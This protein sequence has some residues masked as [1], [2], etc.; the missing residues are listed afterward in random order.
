MRSNI[1]PPLHLSQKVRQDLT[2]ERLRQ[3]QEQRAQQ[4]DNNDTNNNDDTSCSIHLRLVTSDIL[5]ARA[6]N[7][8]TSTLFERGSDEEA[9]ARQRGRICEVDACLLAIKEHDEL[10]ANTPAV[11]DPRAIALWDTA[12]RVEQDATRA[13]T[14]MIR[15]AA[16][17]SSGDDGDDEERSA[18]SASRVAGTKEEV[19]Q[20]QL[21]ALAE[22]TALYRAAT[23]ICP[24]VENPALAAK[25]LIP[26]R[27]GGSGEV[28]TIHLLPDPKANNNLASESAGS[29]TATPSSLRV[30]HIS[31]T[32]NEFYEIPPTDVLIHSGD[33]LDCGTPAEV[34]RF[35]YYLRSH[36]ASR[37]KVVIFVAGNH[38]M[39]AGVDTRVLFHG[40]R[41]YDPQNGT[42][43]TPV[44]LLNDLYF[45]VNFPTPRCVFCL[46]HDA[47]VTVG[48]V[49]IAGTPWMTMGPF[50]EPNMA[51]R[52][53]AIVRC[54][55]P[56][57][58]N[59]KQ[60]QHAAADVLVTHIPCFGVLDQAGL[61]AIGCRAIL[62]ALSAVP[63][64]RVVLHCFGHAHGG[65]GVV[66]AE[67]QEQMSA[68]TTADEDSVNK[69]ELPP[70]YTRWKE[71]FK[72]DFG[73]VFD[74]AQPAAA[75][76]K[77]VFSNAAIANSRDGVPR[78][79]N[80]IRML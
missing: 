15:S 24:E 7:L 4:S 43:L 55:N 69:T 38:E 56:E 42:S 53:D 54:I 51:A 30:V 72:T 71:H 65:F 17:A 8:L 13:A 66:E 5:W 79:F 40:L 28:K 61:M 27:D 60:E 70:S 19:E 52:F 77:L 68:A 76:R 80:L 26:L 62:R 34:A 14:K 57:R 6:Q 49:R 25:F 31:D 59:N 32:H 29:R 9:E 67:L 23:N 64:H 35:N 2:D 37:A 3:Q 45:D 48:G 33:A 16:V 10:I 46:L 75:R 12:T 21:K 41:F 78:Q 22:A 74:A 58:V 47:V 18:A 50:Y 44:D 63:H 36:V 1:I 73:P 20:T 39:L 11:L